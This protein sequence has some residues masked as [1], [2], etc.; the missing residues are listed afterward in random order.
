MSLY[1]ACHKTEAI[2]EVPLTAASG[3]HGI[4]FVALYLKISGVKQISACTSRNH[5]DLI[6]S[7]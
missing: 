1:T 7:V 6:W 3:I 5:V 2:P 4:V